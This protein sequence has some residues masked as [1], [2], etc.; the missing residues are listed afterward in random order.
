MTKVLI[1]ETN[2]QNYQGTND[3]T[4]LWLG[5]SAEFVDE[6]QRAGIAVDYV[7]PKGGFVPLDPRS[8]KYTDAAI[9]AVYRDPDFVERGLKN[10]LAPAAID[11]EAYAAIYYTGGH[12]VMWDFPDNAELHAI[13]SAIYAHG[14]YLLSV[15]HGIAGLLNLKN[16]Q[17]DYVIKG[18]TITGFTTAE[19]ILA[20]KKN[21]VPFL[22]RE[23][24][25]SHGA[26]FQ[27]KRFYKDYAVQDGHLITGQNP[28]SVRS[29][30]RKFIT[31]VQK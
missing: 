9:M 4:G 26:N 20:G 19:E 16:T 11:P 7:S 23:V 13:A 30:A 24:A 22:N 17:G 28:F 6:M 8:M 12:G 27:K 1:V 10:T 5:E 14:G 2:V 29:V 18:K 15:C 21:V 3:P 31:E 25:T